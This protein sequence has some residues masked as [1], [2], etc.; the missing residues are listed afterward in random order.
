MPDIWDIIIKENASPALFDALAKGQ[1][2]KLGQLLRDNA[3]WETQLPAVVLMVE[4]DGS[5]ILLPGDEFSLKPDDA[6]LIAGQHY[7]HSAIHLTS[8]NMNALSYGITGE[9]RRGGWL[10]QWLSLDN[11]MNEK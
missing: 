3:D 1:E 9:D 5:A 8:Q 4:R 11:K 2:I 10:W 7:T 6:I